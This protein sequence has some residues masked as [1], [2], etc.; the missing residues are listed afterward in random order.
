MITRDELQREMKRHTPPRRRCDP[1]TGLALVNGAEVYFAKART[2]L[3]ANALCV[4]M[5]Q[6]PVAWGLMPEMFSDEDFYRMGKELGH[7]GRV[8]LAAAEQQTSGW[9]ECG[10]P[11]VDT[12]SK[13]EG[14][15]QYCRWDDAEGRED[16]DDA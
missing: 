7:E 10:D 14:R 5:S 3:L 6:S 1:V 16:D 11:L 2:P 12:Y 4:V 9:C 8:L 13:L 15:C